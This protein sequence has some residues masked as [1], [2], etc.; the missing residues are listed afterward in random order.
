MSLTVGLLLS[1]GIP[2]SSE[3]ILQIDGCQDF[4]V[5]LSKIITDDIT[6]FVLV[7]V[8]VHRSFI[9]WGGCVWIR[10]CLYVVFTK[11]NIKKIINK[12]PYLCFFKL[13]S[14]EDWAI[15]CMMKQ[16]RL[17]QPIR[18]RDSVGDKGNCHLAPDSKSN[19]ARVLNASSVTTYKII[20][21]NRPTG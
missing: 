15:K 4:F 10:A 20:I 8:K 6:G 9:A 11:R 3:K 17:Y 1:G 2:H 21:V 14:G 19:V 13:V 5:I 16:R 7:I 12:Y 18:I